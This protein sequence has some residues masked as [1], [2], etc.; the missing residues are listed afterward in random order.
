MSEAADLRERRVDRVIARTV[1]AL[2]AGRDE[3]I[4]QVAAATGIAKSTLY[5]RID[6]ESPFKAFE[7]AVLAD[8]FDRPISDLYDGLDG[9]IDPKPPVVASS[10]R[11]S[12]SS[13]SRESA[14]E[15][16]QKW[17]LEAA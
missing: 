13:S 12:Y 9:R 2:A 15:L 6:G 16:M 17:S 1:S 5:R 8:Y 3:T 7:V 4:E 11:R 14:T 10:K